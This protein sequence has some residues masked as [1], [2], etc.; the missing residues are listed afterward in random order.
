MIP[1]RRPTTVQTHAL[2]PGVVI[3]KPNVSLSAPKIPSTKEHYELEARRTRSK[4][5]HTVDPPPPRVDK[6]T[7]LGPMARYMR[8]QTTA[9]ANVITPAQASKQQYP[10]QFLRH[11]A[12][13]VLNKTSGQSLQ[14]RQLCQ[15]PKFL[16]IW[17]TSYSNELFRLCQGVGKGSKFPKNQRMED[18]NTF[19]IIIFEDIPQ[20]RRNKFSTP[21]LC[22]RSDRKSKIPIVYTLP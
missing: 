6:A 13:T 5:P 1:M 8:S 15:H 21:W 14:Y 20:D 12:M 7:D 4:V 2:L 17:N 10:S 16:H 18:M 19:R 3:Q 9:T 11:M 22:V